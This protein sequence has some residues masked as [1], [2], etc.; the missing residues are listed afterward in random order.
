[1][2]STTGQLDKPQKR[3]LW[4]KQ[5]GS[6]L[7]QL[8]ICDKLAGHNYFRGLRLQTCVEGQQRV[9]HPRHGQSWAY[10]GLDLHLSIMSLSAHFMANQ[11]LMLQ[12]AGMK[13]S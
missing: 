8:C 4:L 11:S 1:M 6:L 13:Q 5:P 12:A 10:H 7:L 2:C 3:Q 9:V